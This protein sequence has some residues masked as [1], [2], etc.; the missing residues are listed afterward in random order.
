MSL[1]VRL[2]VF[3]AVIAAGAA[4]LMGLAAYAVTA[5][6][7]HGEADAALA[8][9]AAP[10]L[11]DLRTGRAGGGDPGPG[12]RGRDGPGRVDY[13]TQALMPDGTVVPLV[14]AGVRLPVDE[15]DLALAG[16]A[17][18]EQRFRT[19]DYEGTPIRMLTE[20]AGRGAGAIQTARDWSESGAVLRSLSLTLLM[21]G[22]LVAALSAIGG[23]LLAAR[24]TGRLRAL[25]VASETVGET[26]RL[27]VVVPGEGPDEVG[28]LAGSF[29]LMLARL[30]AS[31]Q[32]QQR[33]VQDAGHELRTP[34]TSLRTNVEL[35]G[36][37]GE[38]PQQ[39]RERI[40]ADLAGETGELTALVN[41]IIDLGTEAPLN[42]EPSPV[43]LADVAGSAVA[44][45][46]RRSGRD[47]VL[48]ADDSVV[49]GNAAAL[50]RAVWNLI[51]NA[52]KFS[53]DGPITV[54]VS[55][56]EVSV[57]DEG[58]GIAPED[59]PHVFDRFYRAA[60]ARSQPGSGLGLS[61]V[62]EVARTH[63]GQAFARNRDS[64]HQG[65]SG[66][67]AAPGRAGGDDGTEVGGAIVGL[68]LPLA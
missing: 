12:G 27:D 13:P 47:V 21:I 43:A 16:S 45:A 17:A 46:R 52:A 63:G 7:L 9:A 59:L 4:C 14:L 66:R 25:T 67:S 30:A 56:G 11:A 3:F 62:S 29:N 51:D 33:L 68:R 65:A 58:P 53:P 49:L 34:L 54:A 42:A 20:S 32:Q 40:V 22:L 5:D 60:G 26:G 23:W 39:D 36:H 8:R 31:R 15:A 38:L 19:D 2:A 10:Y 6:R 64:T 44:R 55:A 61:I 57:A 24:L 48:Q 1:Q 50:E 18:I 41:E 37:F 35:L 28:R